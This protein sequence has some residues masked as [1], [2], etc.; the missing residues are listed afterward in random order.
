MY[1]IGVTTE[2]KKRTLPKMRRRSLIT[3]DKVRTS[4]E[5]A[6]TDEEK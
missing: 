3:P 5:A 6:P 4:E 2:P 1:W